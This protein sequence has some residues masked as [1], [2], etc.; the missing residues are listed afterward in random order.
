MSRDCALCLYSRVPQ[1]KANI[2]SRNDVVLRIK[3]PYLSTVYNQIYAIFSACV[4]SGEGHEFSG[5]SLRLTRDI[6]DRYYV[7]EAKRP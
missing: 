1:I 4:E 7:F 3:F 6:S 2:L 5:K